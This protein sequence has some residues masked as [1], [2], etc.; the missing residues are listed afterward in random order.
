[1]F[2]SIVVHGLS[3][4][5]LNGFYK[6]LRVPTIRDHPVEIILLSE[7]EPVPNNS[8]VNRRG[9]SVVLNNRFSSIVGEQPHV[10]HE[11]DHREASDAIALRRSGETNGTDS[12]LER[13]STKGSSREF[14]KAMN[15]R[16]MV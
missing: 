7:N 13:F 9:H 11:N 16:N 8:V 14:D 5:V 4:P 12:S 15:T 3:I 6:W 1:V 10:D 2:F